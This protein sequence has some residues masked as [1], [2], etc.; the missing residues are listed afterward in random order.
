MADDASIHQHISA[1][2]QEER[3]L[4]GRLAAGQISR[5]EEHARLRDVEVRLDQYWDL[6]R[7]RN[8]RREYD[9]S[10]DDAEVRPERVVENY[11]G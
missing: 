10:P 11:E 8:A 2:V 9:E 4:R 3:E 6:L 1:L 5:E 7:Q